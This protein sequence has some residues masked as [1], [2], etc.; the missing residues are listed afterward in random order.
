MLRTTLLLLLCNLTFTLNCDCALKHR[1]LTVSCHL[2]VHA[3]L[4]TCFLSIFKDN[5]L[6]KQHVF[7]FCT[8]KRCNHTCKKREGRNLV[9]KMKEHNIQW[10]LIGIILYTSIVFVNKLF[11]PLVDVSSLWACCPCTNCLCSGG[12]TDDTRVSESSQGSELL[13]RLPLISSLSK[14]TDNISVT[15]QGLVHGSWCP[16]SDWGSLGWLRLWVVIK[17]F[18]PFT[19][20][21]NEKE[22]H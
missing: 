1:I 18:K 21:R 8:H 6:N 14:T 17:L 9:C 11:F 22:I 13:V 5:I 7:F 15:E 2:S 20:A 3:Q 4:C 10:F 19:C 16:L 12:A